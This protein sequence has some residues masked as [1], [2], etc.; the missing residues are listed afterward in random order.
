MIL[1]TTLKTHLLKLLIGESSLELNQVAERAKRL[2]KREERQ[3][4][5]Y[6]DHLSYDDLDEDAEAESLF[7]GCVIVLIGCFIIAVVLVTI[8]FRII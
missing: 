1:L 2:A 3:A 7:D 4:H 8:I 5:L 6:D